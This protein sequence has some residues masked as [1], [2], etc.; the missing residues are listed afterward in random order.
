M[1]PG[2]SGSQPFFSLSPW[3]S[4]LGWGTGEALSDSAE[5]GW[6]PHGLGASMA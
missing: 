4:V 3:A 2:L 5:G 1:H 6:Y